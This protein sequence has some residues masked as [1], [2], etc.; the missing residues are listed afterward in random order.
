MIL[1]GLHKLQTKFP[2]VSVQLLFEIKLKVKE[3][4]VVSKSVHSSIKIVDIFQETE[5]DKIFLLVIEK[6]EISVVEEIFSEKFTFTLSNF[7][8]ELLSYPSADNILGTALSIE[9]TFE[10]EAKF[11]HA[12]SV[13]VQEV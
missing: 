13:N 5:E 6:A 11:F 9:E 12:I 1:I 4:V 2:A 8:F 3:F 7:Q 10:I